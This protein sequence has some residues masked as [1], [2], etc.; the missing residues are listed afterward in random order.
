METIHLIRNGKQEAARNL[1]VCADGTLRGLIAKGKEIPMFNKAVLE[2]LGVSKDEA[3][4]RG[5]SASTEWMLKLGEN[6]GGL[7]VLRQNEY[8]RWAQEHDSPEIRR[9]RRRA[10]RNAL[11]EG[12]G[13]LELARNAYRYDQERHHDAFNR[14]MEDEHNDGAR[15][16]QPTDPELKTRYESLKAQYPRA[17]LY[18]RAEA[19]HEG[20]HW[21]DNAGAGAAGEKAMLLVKKGAS[22]AEV[23]AA[24]AVR[25]EWVD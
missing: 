9:E 16:P 14:M 6:E 3:L 15:F 5:L 25:R 24:L 19:Q 17:A 22:E 23:E 2:R 12:L 8:Q 4:R 18:L 11:V 13:D 21:A 20:A 1:H 7:L 10:E